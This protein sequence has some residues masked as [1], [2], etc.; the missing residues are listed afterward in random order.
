M[1]NLFSDLIGKVK[2]AVVLYREN[3]A[4]RYA[5]I[6]FYLLLWFIASGGR[7]WA[8]ILGALG[9]LLGRM[10]VECRD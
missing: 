6:A 4:A 10:S 7:S 5:S 8:V 9:I 1:E 3:R 2:N